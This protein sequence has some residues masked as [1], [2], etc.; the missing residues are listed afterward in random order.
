MTAA[1]DRASKGLNGSPGVILETPAGPGW[2]KQ[3]S[4]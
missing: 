4:L 3:G 1:V 2:N